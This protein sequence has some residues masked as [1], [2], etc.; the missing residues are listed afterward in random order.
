MSFQK[1]MSDV[2]KEELAVIKKLLKVSEKEN[3]YGTEKDILKRTAYS[4]KSH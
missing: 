3:L 4:H 1:K 2:T